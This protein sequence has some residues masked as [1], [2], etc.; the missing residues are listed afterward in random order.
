VPKPAQGESGAWS[1]DAGQRK[2]Y[3]YNLATEAIADEPTR[4]IPLIRSTP[5]TPRK[6]DIPNATLSEIR[7]KVEK[8]IKQ[9]YLR[10]VNAP[11]WVK[12]VLKAW[13]E[14]S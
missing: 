14:L 13:M 3:L 4:I 12:P 10:Q 7:A 5:D 11:G 1:E 8:H 2:W 9:T 6:H